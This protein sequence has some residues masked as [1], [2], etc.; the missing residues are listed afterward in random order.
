MIAGKEFTVEAC[1][2]LLF[3]VGKCSPVE[4]LALNAQADFDKFKPTYE[5]FKYALEHLEVQ[6]DNKWTAVKVKDRDVYMPLGIEENLGGLN[7]LALW[8]INNVLVEVFQK[9]GE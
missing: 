2:D 9:S 8:F 4:L 7:A 5:L 6:V 1:P 3:R